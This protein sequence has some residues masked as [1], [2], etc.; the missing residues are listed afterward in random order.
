MPEFY[1]EDEIEDQVALEF[2]AGSAA[3]MSVVGLPVTVQ[4]IRGDAEG[5]YETARGRDTYREETHLPN[6]RTHQQVHGSIYAIDPAEN[7]LWLMPQRL[8]KVS[9][10]A[11]FWMV[12]DFM[13]SGDPAYRVTVRESRWRDSMRQGRRFYFPAYTPKLIEV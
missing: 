5:I 8:T 11:G 10:N 13:M 1:A 6:H 4:A 2:I 3:V 12:A 7:V 9:I